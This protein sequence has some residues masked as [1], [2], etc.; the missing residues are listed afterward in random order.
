MANTNHPKKK[1]SQE[2]AV[3]EDDRNLARQNREEY[4]ASVLQQ[5]GDFE[6]KLDE[7]EA[8]M[9][10]SGW[11][12]ISDYRGQLDDLRLR[13]KGLRSRTEELEAVPDP[14]WPAVYEEMEE[15]LAD[16]GGSVADLTAGLSLVLP[17]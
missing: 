4:V 11:D 6:E 12:D 17:E 7:L 2:G 13:L 10:S 16:V 1:A 3:C 14:S 9:E 8:D 5:V 15:S